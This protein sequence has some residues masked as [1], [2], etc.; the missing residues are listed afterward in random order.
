MISYIP[1]TGYFGKVLLATHYIIVHSNKVFGV[2]STL[3]T[4][5]PIMVL[6][7]DYFAFSIA[8][9]MRKVLQRQTILPSVSCHDKTFTTTDCLAFSVMSWQELHN[10]RLI[11]PLQC[12][13]PDDKSFKSSSDCLTFIVDDGDDALG[14]LAQCSPT[15]CIIQ[16]DL[17]TL[18]TLG[19]LN[20][21]S[22]VT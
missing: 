1:D 21:T 7:L 6:Q 2:G 8:D 15:I 17:E 16:L 12:H 18:V 4:W 14:Q 13:W 10:Y 19:F 22:D 3:L 9:R 5:W 20:D 11:F